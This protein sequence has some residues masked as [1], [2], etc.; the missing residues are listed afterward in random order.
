[1]LSLL[2]YL[3]AFYAY[4][5]FALPGL[6]GK[7]GEPHQGEASPNRWL[8]ALAL[9]CFFCALLSKTVTSTFPAALLLLLWWKKKRLSLR[10]V[11]LT[12]PFLLL[13]IVF[14]LL[15]A[16]METTHVGAQ[17]TEWSLT[18]LDRIL[19][20][21][22]I[23]WFYAWKLLW[24]LNLIFIYPRWEIDA[25]QWWQLLF[26]LATL[27]VVVGLWW[28]RRRIGT[29]PLVA[30][31]FFLGS[32]FPALGFFNVFPMRFSFVADHFQYL[33]GIG[34]IVLGSAAT[35][36]W[37][38][39]N[40]WDRGSAPRYSA[41]VVL[42]LL[43]GLTWQRIPAYRNQEIL[44][45]DTL[46]RNPEAWIA[47]NNLGEIL[48]AQGR[49]DEAMRHSLEALARKPDLPQAH[50]NLANAYFGKG[51]FDLAVEHYEKLLGLDPDE[52]TATTAHNNLAQTFEKLNRTKEARRHYEEALA[53]TPGHPDV[54]YKLANLLVGE[55]EYDQAVDHYKASLN[56]RPDHYYTLYRLGI[57]LQAQGKREEARG[58]MSKAL[59]LARM[60]GEPR[61]VEE[62]EARLRSL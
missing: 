52:I 60:A 20:A 46:A 56:G 53:I 23:P 7:Q 6:F 34:L 29:G 5:R 24:P 48:F 39:K 32:L 57:V 26:P 62:I 16:F 33:A 38:K 11:L 27:S 58:Y 17:G 4:F 25:A 15:T 51:Q 40:R 41:L 42:V 22:R 1:M 59:S 19:L 14:G 10:D 31:L 28:F 44:W 30:V 50:G 47:H 45:R 61:L 36:T 18:F 21:G 35:V 55:R 3:C 8:Y 37:L 49:V 54:H 2:F 13:G 9:G 43:G 12:S